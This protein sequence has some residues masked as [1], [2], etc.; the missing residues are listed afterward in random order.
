MFDAESFGTDSVAQDLSP[1]GA[2]DY[3]RIR[4]DVR[5]CASPLCGGF[6][7]QR[8]NR[9][10]TLCADGE[11]RS[12]C[13]VADLDLSALALNDEQASLVQADPT[14][15]VLRGSLVSRPSS[16][17]DLGRLNVTEAWLGHAS[18]TPSGAF[19]RVRSEGI[20]CI[21]TPCLS[22][23]AELLN[24]ALP[25]VRA[26]ELDLTS[27]AQ[28]PGDAVAQL[29]AVD[30]LLVAARPRLARGPAGRALALQASEYYIPL[31]PAEVACG[32]RGLGARRGQLLL[33]SGQQ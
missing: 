22:L 32:S 5:R 15:F 29:S 20:V 12:E 28:D 25:S 1:A 10:N 31:P 18:A 23:S 4:P 27:V 33:I 30:G 16:F 11:R 24:H 6:F 21:T 8:V 7:V 17:G 3:L 2:A 9:S 19:L 13:Y 26:A 14:H